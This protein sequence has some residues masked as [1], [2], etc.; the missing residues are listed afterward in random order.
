[1]MDNGYL[2]NGIGIDARLKK[3]GGLW[4]VTLELPQWLHDDVLT[5]LRST[6]NKL[7]LKEATGDTLVFEQRLPL[8]FF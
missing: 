2:E 7:F 5:E 6:T 4:Q 1:M 8:L 3:S